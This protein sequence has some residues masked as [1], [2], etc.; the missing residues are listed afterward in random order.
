MNKR[1]WPQGIHILIAS[2]IFL[3]VLVFIYLIVGRHNRRLD[4]TRDKIYS[5]SQ[6]TV[7]VLKRMEGPI[8]VRAFFAEEDPLA[9]DFKILLKEISTHHPHFRYEFFDPDRAPSEARRRGVE[10]YRVTVIEYQNHEERIKEISEEAVTNALIRL[11]HPQKQVLCFAQG[12]GENGLD[13]EERTGLAGL[14][15]ALE[16]HHY[17]VKGVE[18]LKS[19]LPAECQVV[20]MAGPRY[21]LLP[22][23]MELLQDLPRQGKSFLL[24]I[25]PMDAGTGKSF[26]ELVKPFGVTLSDDV[27]VDKVS[28]VFGGD[29]LIPLVAQYAAHPITRGFQAAIFLSVSRTVKKSA[30]VPQEFEVTELARTL[31]GTWGETNLKNLENGDADF[32][33]ATD[34]AGP[35]SLAVAVEMKKKEGAWRAAIVGDS[36]FLT[37]AHLKVAGNQDFAFNMLEWLAKDDRWISIRTQ[38]TRFEPLFLKMNQTVGAASF[39]VGFLPLAALVTGSAG[40][41]VRRRRSV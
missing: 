30:D 23:E 26:R 2:G 18:M 20:V 14:K 13:D 33:A 7:Q 31:P 15:Q 9:Q 6:E 27:V 16:A 41:W 22:K 17:E 29:F 12:H 19:S 25:D 11:A 37:N 8:T 28:K 38:Q 10:S 5:V 35:L 34:F 24:L 1:H 3:T 40:I 39:A 32:D 4:L 36:D 21:E